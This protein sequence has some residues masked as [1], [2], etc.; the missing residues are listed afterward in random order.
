LTPT[1]V[2]TA[3]LVWGGAL[4]DVATASLTLP[5]IG[6]FEL[7]SALLFD[8]GVYV[9]VIGIVLMAFEAF[10]DEPAEVAR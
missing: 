6:S 2:A 9:T 1:L 7:S 8:V 5:V 4:L 3:P 10:G